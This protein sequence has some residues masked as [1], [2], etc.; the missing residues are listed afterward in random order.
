MSTTS[1]QAVP[2]EA[3]RLVRGDVAGLLCAASLLLLSVPALASVAVALLAA[4]AGGLALARTPRRLAPELR[5]PSAFFVASIV[6]STCASIDLQHSLTHLVVMVPG[7]LLFL[8]VG[9]LTDRT[10]L[11]TLFRAS[12]LLVGALGVAVVATVLAHGAGES[13]DR[14]D[15][16]FLI[17][18]NDVCFLAVMLPAA[19][20]LPVCTRRRSDGALAVLAIV[21][22]LAA[23]VALVSRL[24]VLCATG[25]IVAYVAVTR[26]RLWP[27]LGATVAVAAVVGGIDASLGLGWLHKLTTVSWLTRLPTW[28]VALDM[29]RDAP[30]IG[31]GPRTYGVLF[32]DYYERTM[33]SNWM[34]PRHTPWAHSLFLET[35]AEQGLVGLATLIFVLRAAMRI[36]F[37]KRARRNGDGVVAS[38]QVALAILLVTYLFEASFV[39]LW[40]VIGTCFWLGVAATLAEPAGD[41][42]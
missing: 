35:L 32:D 37:G 25:A 41:D 21:A 5:L 11:F 42:A 23:S 36:V 19:L 39:R 29:F 30:V 7:V 4:G 18:P 27:T 3:R 6:I 20:A 28:T 8:V 31:H 9:Q 2:F 15:T 34:E 14:L 17:K 16:T 24:G 10:R 13:L 33:I 40:T 26:G 22:T 12:A 38:V 1:V